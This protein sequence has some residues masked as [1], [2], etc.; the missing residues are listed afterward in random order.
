MNVF[1]DI[2]KS[3]IGMA[4]IGAFFGLVLSVVFDDFLR[5]VKRNIKR[6]WKRIFAPKINQGSIYFTLND[7]STDFYVLDGDG[8][9]EFNE[10]DIECRYKKETVTLPEGIK[11]LRQEVEAKE[12]KRKEAGE[13]YRWNGVLYGLSKYRMSR[14]GF[15]EVPHVLF[16]FHQTDYY[17]FL[18]TNTQLDRSLPNGKTIRET[19]IPYTNLDKVQ[20]ILANGFGVVIV[21]ITEDERVVL[22]RRTEFAGARAGELDVSVVEGV[23]PELDEDSKSEGPDLFRA[24]TRGIDEELGIH[25]NESAIS[26]LGYGIDTK[27]Y[28]WNMIG[29]VQAHGITANDIEVARGKGASGKW[30]NKEVEYI[31]LTPANIAKV[32]MEEAMWDT[33]KVALY[34]TGVNQL[35]KRQLEKALKKYK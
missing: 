18:A 14:E 9:I 1:I 24:A 33:A 26:F 15:R 34:W 16:N 11:E 10:G 35:G 17:T 28:Q 6:K 22:T 23:Q 13:D 25:I 4:L 7:K 27:Y 30:E 5:N 32:L 21:V 31:T 8:V 3:D 2:F 29:Y 12:L 20:P 19:Y